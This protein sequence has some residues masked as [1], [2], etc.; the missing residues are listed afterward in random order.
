MN[1]TVEI[2]NFRKKTEHMVKGRNRGDKSKSGR[3]GSYCTRTG[4]SGFKC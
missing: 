3:M 2:K 1:F 4:G